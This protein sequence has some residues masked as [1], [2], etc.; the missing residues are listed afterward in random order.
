MSSSAWTRWRVTC[1]TDSRYEYI[2][3]PSNKGKP[4]KCPVDESHTIV[5]AETCPLSE[6]DPTRTTVAVKGPTEIFGDLATSS[7]TPIVECTFPYGRHP[8]L[9]TTNTRESGTVTTSA[10]LAVVSTGTTTGSRAELH[11]HRRARYNP[12]YAMRARFTAIFETSVAATTQWAG[13]GDSTNGLFF[14]YSGTDFGVMR[15]HGG[16]LRIQSL[17]VTSA[18]TSAGNVTVTLNGDAVVVA[19]SIGSIHDVVAELAAADYSAAGGGW[20]THVDGDTVHFVAVEAGARS[21][22]YAYADTDTTGAAASHSVAQSGAASTDVFV[23]S[24]AWNQDVADGTAHLPPIDASNGNVYQIEFQ[25]LGFGAVNFSIEN[26]ITGA[27]VVVHRIEYANG[28]TATSLRNP[29]FPLSV[30]VD[31]VATTTD[32]VVRTACLCAT[33]VGHVN[34]LLGP[35][36]SAFGSIDGVSLSDWTKV[37]WIRNDVLLQGA[38]NKSEVILL[39][40]HAYYKSTEAGL[41]RLYRGAAVA[42]PDAGTAWTAVSAASCVSYSAYASTAETVSSGDVVFTV[43][44]GLDSSIRENLQDLQLYLQPG[45]TLLVAVKPMSGSATVDACVSLACA[46][47]Q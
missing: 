1:S 9:S 4:T 7:A 14:G 19:V 27:F 15:R 12:G 38:E 17:Q 21:G 32:L 43:P 13:I 18:A 29:V 45:E 28:S 26:P 30:V 34:L 35:R 41:L 11:T 39:D 31:N 23:A 6:G 8:D 24:T 47:R 42:G 37:L 46:E 25:W 44:M 5:A 22:S 36:S 2:V 16:A 33:S 40:L 10:G 20:C 3:Q